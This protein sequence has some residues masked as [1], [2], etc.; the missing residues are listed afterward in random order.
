M[1]K[2]LVTTML[3]AVTAARA[4]RPSQAAGRKFSRHLL[5][6]AASATSGGGG[7]VSATPET[8]SSGSGSSSGGAGSSDKLSSLRTLMAEESI[9]AYLVPSDDP[10]LSEY[11]APCYERRAFISG[12]TGSAGVAVVT[13][14][15]AYL[16]TDGRYWLQAEQELDGASWKLMKQGSPGCPEVA[17]FLCDTLGGG[18]AQKETPRAVGIDPSVHAAAVAKD[19]ASTLGSRG[20]ELRPIE[21]RNLVDEVWGAARPRPPAGAVR[22]HPA[23]FAGATVGSKLATLARELDKAGAD[24]LVAASLDEVAY[25]FNIRGADIA[26]CP[27]VLAYALVQRTGKGGGA[28]GGSGKHC[29]ATL[30]VDREKLGPEASMQLMADGV[31]IKGYDAITEDLASL[32]KAGSR[33]MVDPKRVNYGLLSPLGYGTAKKGQLVEVANSPITESKAVKNEGELSGMVAAHLRDG[34]AVASFFCWLEE[35]VSG[36]GKRAVSEVEI[37]E[38]VTGFRRRQPHFLDVSFPTIAGA[39]GNG[40]IIHYRAEEASCSAVDDKSLLLLDSG[41]QYEDG[42]TDVT[43]TVHLGEPSETQRECFTRVLKG[44]I[45]LDTA[46]FPENTPGFVLDVFARRSLWEAGMDYAHGTG[47][48]VGAALNVHV[49]TFLSCGIRRTRRGGGGVGTSQ[50]SDCC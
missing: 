39:N 23:E 48:G 21:G 30:Y 36:A 16:W 3:L 47:H 43:R 14:D 10:H 46:V 45:A 28:A 34:A 38:A 20:I 27:V 50:S 19:L 33:L 4:F 18:K 42:T 41:A 32:G 25:L 13:A 24:A 49:R 6:R 8:V 40:A 44:N 26:C 29:Q 37:D 17:K 9:D 35:T 11:V 12:F 7:A 15:E 31:A 22:V 1:R 2:H 5:S